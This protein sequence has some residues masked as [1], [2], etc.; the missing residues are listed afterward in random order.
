M[1]MNTVKFEGPFKAAP[2]DQEFF[3]PWYVLTDDL[4]DSLVKESL[5]RRTRAEDLAQLP[6]LTMRRDSEEYSCLLRDELTALVDRQADREILAVKEG[7]RLRNDPS[8]PPI[9]LIEPNSELWNDLRRVGEAWLTKDEEAERERER[10]ELAAEREQLEKERK[11][12]ER[13]KK[14]EGLPSINLKAIE[15]ITYPLDKLNYAL[16]SHF[17]EMMDDNG[18]VVNFPLKMDRRKRKSGAITL[19]TVLFKE[20][21]DVPG[22]GDQIKELTVFDK[23]VYI[24]CFNEFM[25]NGAYTTIAHIAG[26]MGL[27]ESP[28]P[29]QRKIIGDSLNKMLTAPIDVDNGAEVAVNKKY[30]LFVYHG[31]L[32]PMEWEE[33]TI[34]GNPTDGVVHFFRDPPLM[35]FAEGREQLTTIDSR[36]LKIPL[37]KT[38]GNLKINDYLIDRIAQMKRKK[39][40]LP[41][42]ISLQTLYEECGITTPKQKTRA[43][44][45]IK[46]IL[47]HYERCGW[48]AGYEFKDDAIVII[49]ET[50]DIPG[51]V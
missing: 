18:E 42:K 7:I 44:E 24:A 36:L 27:T 2:K 35:A 10:E 48:V 21:E 32:L 9:E 34:N 12:L 47:G 46:R 19:V 20:L 39:S 49:F 1:W 43:P 4:M 41:Q 15:K 38:E 30:P 6:D 25:N 37:D 8:I 14:R 16:W 5:M 22:L 26:T 50:K 33:A 28:N 13:E 23:L 11:R 17:P 29:R 45:K 3:R 31:V 51:R 40:S